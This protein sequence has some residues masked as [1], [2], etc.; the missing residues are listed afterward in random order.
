MPAFVQS[1]DRWLEY[2]RGHNIEAISEGCI[3]LRK[4]T[5]AR[6]WVHAIDV[7]GAPGRHG[8]AH[9]RLLFEARDRRDVLADD[10]VNGSRCGPRASKSRMASAFPYQFDQKPKLCCMR[11]MARGPY[12]ASP[13]SR[14]RSW[15]M[16]AGCTFS[17]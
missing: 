14:R 15:R 16:F 11:S 1:V 6:N 9:A 17:V 3:L 10:Q 5:G 4:R 8:G 7:P 13:R 12:V 2:D